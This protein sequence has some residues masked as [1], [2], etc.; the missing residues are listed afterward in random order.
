MKEI[1]VDRRQICDYIREKMSDFSKYPV[2]VV[3]TEYHHC[4][5]YGD[6]L[7]I[8]MNGILTLSELNRLGVKKY[9]NDQLKRLSIVDSHVNGIDGISLAVMGLKDLYDNEEEYCP[10][11]NNRLDFLIDSQV[12]AHR[13]ATNYGNEYISYEN[14]ENSMIKAVDIRLLCYIKEKENNIEELTNDEYIKITEKYNHI[15]S[16]ANVIVKQNFDIIMR[17]N[18]EFK[19]TYLD[20]EKI[21]DS[22]KLV[23]R[24]AEY[25][26]K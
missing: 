16:I 21:V 25:A 15:R 8:V 4:T 18:S 19:N 20:L 13:I 26:L 3:N 6:G 14:I 17:E 7:S 11:C 22:P 12:H 5:L 23:L 2:E 1:A 9:S 10:Y 24:N